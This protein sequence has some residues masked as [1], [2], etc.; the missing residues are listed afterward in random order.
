MTSRSEA[1]QLERELE[2]E[3]E[4]DGEPV[5]DLLLQHDAIAEGEVALD[6][7]GVRRL[8]RRLAYLGREADTLRTLKQKV[9]LRYDDAIKGREA[10]ATAVKELL[11]AHLHRVD[12]G[13]VRIPDVGTAFL[14]KRK[15]KLV[16]TDAEAFEAWVLERSKAGK[17][18]ETVLYRQVFDETAARALSLTY[19]VETGEL[20]AGA[21]LVGERREVTVRGAS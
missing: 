16:V 5:V 21:E 2:Q 8:L 6:E 11:T 7:F 10:E 3:V 14:S 18:P 12:G 1:V 20:P 9:T 4:R 17:F 15:P 13:K 19:S